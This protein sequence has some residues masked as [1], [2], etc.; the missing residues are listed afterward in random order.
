MDTFK[1]EIKEIFAK[2]IPIEEKT[3][4]K[5]SADNSININNCSFQINSSY[6]IISSLLALC[7]IVLT[8]FI[9][10]HLQQNISNHTTLTQESNIINERQANR[11]QA[12]IKKVSQCEK[13]TP[14]TIHNELKLLY[15]YNRYR[16]M[17]A[18]VYYSVEESLVKR[19]CD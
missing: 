2:S 17:P 4:E 13:K 12:L 16:E 15:G 18:K 8:T 1:K 9:S 14:N 3:K 7:F 10:L 5:F 11:V 6:V 19:L